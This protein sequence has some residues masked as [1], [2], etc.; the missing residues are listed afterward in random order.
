MDIIYLTYFNLDVLSE[1]VE[2]LSQYAVIFLRWEGNQLSNYSLNLA[3]LLRSLPM[4]NISG[5]ELLY[6]R[7][8]NNRRKAKYSSVEIAS[9][10]VRIVKD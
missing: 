9:A 8:H 3:L 1:P 2:K 4:N 6:E 5:N 10:H 7:N